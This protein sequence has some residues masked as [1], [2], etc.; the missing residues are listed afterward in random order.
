MYVDALALDTELTEDGWTLADTLADDDRHGDFRRCPPVEAVLPL[1]SE[2]DKVAILNPAREAAE[3]LG[4]A[5]S[6]VL[7]RRC[8]AYA[9][10]R[11]EVSAA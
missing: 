9:R 8:R 11:R 10:I 2:D 5:R 6:S 3:M 7:T 1:L 4:L